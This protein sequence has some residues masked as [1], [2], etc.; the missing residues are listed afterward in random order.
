MLLTSFQEE[1]TEDM[2]IEGF[3]MAYADGVSVNLL[4]DMYVWLMVGMIIGRYHHMF[5]G[6]PWRVR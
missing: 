4:I 6:R 3:L 1:T 2:L 5:S